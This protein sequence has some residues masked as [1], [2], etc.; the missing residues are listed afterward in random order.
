MSY[1]SR[2]VILRTLIF[3][4]LIIFQIWALYHDFEGAK[5]THVLDVLI[6][7]FGGY[8]RFLTGV[9]NLD[10]DL[11]M[12]KNLA[13]IFS[14]VLIMLRSVKAQIQGVSKSRISSDK[15]VLGGWGR[16]WSGLDSAKIRFGSDW[17]NQ[18]S[19]QWPSL[20]SLSLGF[21]HEIF[22]ELFPHRWNHRGMKL[23]MGSKGNLV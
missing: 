12:V 20:P 1:K 3:D 21:I 17:V 11:D 7:G 4:T 23:C 5:N 6:W 18:K 16:V 19:L 10:L 22:F 8:W 9:W 14:E 2:F 15:L 13:W